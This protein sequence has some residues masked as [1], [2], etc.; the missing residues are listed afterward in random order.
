MVSASWVQL[1]MPSLQILFFQTKAIEGFEFHD[2]C[3]FV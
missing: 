1:D 3:S 2:P